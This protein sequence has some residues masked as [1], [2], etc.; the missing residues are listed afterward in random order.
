[1]DY[2]NHRLRQVLPDGAQLEVETGYINWWNA[3][4]AVRVN[5]VLVHESHPGRT[6]LWPS[7][8]GQ[9][10]MD[11]QREEQMQAQQQR[12]AAQWARNKP[13][14]PVSIFL[15]CGCTAVPLGVLAYLVCLTTPKSSECTSDPRIGATNSA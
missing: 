9:G 8:Q 15:F 3:G 14:L 7:L 12:D 1:M 6:L 5:G 10:P 13:S 11:P 2:R 4:I